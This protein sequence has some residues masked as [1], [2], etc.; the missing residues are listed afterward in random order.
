[1]K[2]FLPWLLPARRVKL[3]GIGPTHPG[4]RLRISV[5]AGPLVDADSD[6]L[7]YVARFGGTGTACVP[8]CLP[9]CDLHGWCDLMS[10][11]GLG[12]WVEIKAIRLPND[13]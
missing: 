8:G 9:G 10:T 7:Y 4:I 5:P 11:N 3:A 13:E 12:C 2:R 6:H 1:M